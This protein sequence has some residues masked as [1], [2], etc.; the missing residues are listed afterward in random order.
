MRKDINSKITLTI[1]AKEVKNFSK[2]MMRAKQ[3]FK[4]RKKRENLLVEIY[5]L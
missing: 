2:K 3:S 5:H 1:Y 4:Q